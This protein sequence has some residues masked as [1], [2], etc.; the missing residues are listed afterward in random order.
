MREFGP[1]Y[2]DPTYS[3]VLSGIAVRVQNRAAEHAP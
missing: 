2:S 1:S 3:E